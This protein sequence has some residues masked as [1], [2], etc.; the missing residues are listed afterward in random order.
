MA[1][2]SLQQK[3]TLGLAAI[4]IVIGGTMVYDAMSTSSQQ[5]TTF[6][7]AQQAAEDAWVLPDPTGSADETN[8]VIDTGKPVK[9]PAVRDV[10]AKLQFFRPSTGKSLVHAKPLFVGE[11][12]DSFSL[13]RGP[14]HYV[15]TA[16]PGQQ[17]NVAIAGHRTGWGSPFLR[18]NDLKPGD[19]IILTTR[20][21]TRYR[22]EVLR[23]IYVA[24]DADRV[25][26]QEPN[27][28]GDRRITLTTCDPPHTSDRR[29]IVQGVL[30]P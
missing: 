18:L 26:K 15:G 12:T 24:A 2:I 16:L 17:G 21:G 29:L 5:T 4:F 19:R 7:T 13:S 8:P 23:K 27:A 22:Y 10:I 30:L 25:L 6:D 1:R 28:D 3:L 9:Q 20:E 11:G 14:G